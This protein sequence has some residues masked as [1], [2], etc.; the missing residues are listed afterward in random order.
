M[1]RGR[2]VV[3]GSQKGLMLPPG[4]SLNAI[5][6][7]ALAASKNSNL[8]KSYWR[9]EEMIE[10]NRKGFFPILRPPICYTA[11]AKL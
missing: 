8:P 10:A 5:S 3:S 11:C 9:W 1:G 7:K 4:L 6:A 2:D